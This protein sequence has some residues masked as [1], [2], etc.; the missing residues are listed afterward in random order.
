MSDYNNNNQPRYQ[1]GYG[2]PQQPDLSGMSAPGGDP[3]A[4]WRKPEQAN[5]SFL[6]DNPAPLGAELQQGGSPLFSQQ[7][8]SSMGDNAPTRIAAPVQ[9]VSRRTTPAPAAPLE[10]SFQQNDAPAQQGYPQP[11]A[12]AAAQE[13]P[14]RRRR[15]SAP[16][17]Q[18][19]APAGEYAAMEQRPQQPVQQPE[20]P[21]QGRPQGQRPMAPQQQPMQQRPQQPMMPD[22]PAYDLFGAGDS[23]AQQ[24]GM[25]RR[26]AVAGGQYTGARTA[27]PE[28]G[29]SVADRA[30][31]AKE[32]VRAE[33]DDFGDFGDFNDFDQQERQPQRP[34]QQP[35]QPMQGRPQGQ[36]PMGPQGQP[37]PQRPQQGMQRQPAYDDDYGYNSGYSQ[38][39]RGPYEDPR[40]RR[41]SATVNREPYDFEEEDEEE[42]RGGILLPLIIVLLVVGAL[43]A[44]ICLPDWSKVSGPVGNTM[45]NLKTSVVTVFSNVKDMILPQNS[46]L[47]SFNV[48]TADTAAPANVRFT[49]QTSKNIEG[50][51]IENDNGFTI[52][53]KLF[54]DQLVLA[55]K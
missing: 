55:A 4:A 17:E 41:P 12:P 38:P 33:M 21:M 31:Q 10:E 13:Q 50:I 34:V 18:P 26:T 52:Y 37:M 1:G 25:P 51:R 35:R 8:F 11:G 20:M 29:M 47:K 46:A 5:S 48:S 30:Q 22:E 6:A 44:G 39:P 3:F 7:D 23:E 19:A 43:L 27:M 42:R 16:V 32:R 14:R 53:S 40:G 2:Q 49:V 24:P 15:S 54:S 28:R 45:G 9:M 36:R